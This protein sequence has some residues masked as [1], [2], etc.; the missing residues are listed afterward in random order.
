MAGTASSAVGTDASAA[1]T[2]GSKAPQRSSR[3]TR[4]PPAV[5]ARVELRD[6]ELVASVRAE[7][8]VRHEL[9]GHL[10]RELGSR[11][12]AHVDAHELA[13]L[14]GVV[15]LEL[16]PLARQ[17]GLLAVGLR[18]AP[19]R[20]R[21]PPS[22]S[23]RP[24]RPRCRPSAS[25]VTRVGRRDADE[26]ARRRHD[27][28]VRAEHGGAQPADALQSMPF[29]MPGSHAPL[30]YRSMR[31]AAVTS[32]PRRIAPPP[33]PRVMTMTA[34]R[35]NSAP[36]CTAKRAATQAPNACPAPSSKPSVHCT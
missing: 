26:Q 29:S 11:P 5:A 13:V 7:R 21:R 28:V 8:V 20:T 6:A 10:F 32:R 15:G 18:A 33:R 27:A 24:P 19:R 31:S 23:R 16:L 25:C 36:R 4:P 17:V 14:A 1:T 3:R 30:V 12:A 2:S 22:T 34:Q 35:T 9:L